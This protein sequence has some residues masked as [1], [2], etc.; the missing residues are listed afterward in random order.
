MPMRATVDSS[1]LRQAAKIVR[2]IDPEIRKGFMRDLK[3]DL[4]PYANKIAKD[5]PVLGSPGAMRGFG[6]SGRTSWGAVQGSAYVSPGGGRGSLARIEIYGRG[7]NRAALKYADL[8]GTRQKYNDG[9]MAKIGDRN[10]YTI[11]GQGR[12]MVDRLDQVAKLSQN[13]KGGRFVWAGFMK[14][15]PWFVK[16]AISRLDQYSDAITRRLTR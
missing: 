14:H 4:K 16:V 8:A 11:R 15:R 12:A 3:S 7:Q 9:A 2:E 13:G 1:A 6:H 5:V 10:L